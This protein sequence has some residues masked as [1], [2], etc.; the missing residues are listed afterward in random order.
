MGGMH[1][2]NITIQFLMLF[3]AH[4]R[5]HTNTYVYLGKR[6]MANLNQKKEVKVRCARTINSFNQHRKVLS[7]PQIALER[8]IQLLH[9]LC[10]VHLQNELHSTPHLTQPQLRQLSRTYMSVLRRTCNL[11]KADGHWARVSDSSF[12]QAIAQPPLDDILMVRRLQFLGRLLVSDNRLVRGMLTIHGH[13]GF[14]EQW[15][16]DLNTVRARIP[17][18]RDLP[19][20]DRGTA[21]TWITYIVLSSD[22]WSALLKKNLLSLPKVPLLKMFRLPQNF[23]HEV[24]TQ[25]PLLAEPAQENQE[26]PTPEQDHAQEAPPHQTPE[27]GPYQCHLCTKSFQQWRSLSMHRRRAHQLISGIAL[28][29][30]G[31]QCTVCLAQL[32]TRALLIEHLNRRPICGIQTLHFVEPM[33][34][35]EYG[36]NIAQLRAL[37]SGLSRSAAPRTGPIP[38]IDGVPRS[39]AAEPINPFVVQQLDDPLS[40]SCSSSGRNGIDDNSQD[41]LDNIDQHADM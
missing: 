7:S 26:N 12:L 15:L 35:H 20:A 10:L 16:I 18:L 4:A 1:Y 32:K 11:Q 33:N 28:R 34:E 39:Q 29:A 24:E 40:R 31:T 17:Q 30:R 9:T 21:P 22:A 25:Q 8:R 2:T 41:D 23:I 3:M 38:L 13:H 19:E 14:W 36:A 27:P 37:E 5:P 6:T